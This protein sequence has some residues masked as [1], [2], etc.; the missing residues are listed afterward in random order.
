MKGYDSIKKNK[1]KSSHHHNLQDYDDAYAKFSPKEAE[2]EIEF[3]SD[4][5]LNIAHNT[6]DRH[7]KGNGKVA[8]IYNGPE[9]QKWKTIR[10]I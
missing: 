10:R 4:G 5:K 6:V 7:A 2:S 8:L 9:F 1:S 3:F